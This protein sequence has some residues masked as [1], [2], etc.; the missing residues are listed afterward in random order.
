MRSFPG[1]SLCKESKKAGYEWKVTDS[2]KWMA[3]PTRFYHLSSARAASKLHP[4]PER[5]PIGTRDKWWKL[6]SL[7]V[8]VSVVS[9][10]AIVM[11]LSTLEVRKASHTP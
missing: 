2:G 8:V 6:W 9:V 7:H 5:L 11:V 10:V 4:Y 1:V 3:A